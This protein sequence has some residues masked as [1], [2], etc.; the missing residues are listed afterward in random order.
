MIPTDPP[1]FMITFLKKIFILRWLSLLQD[2]LEE[3]KFISI[4][5]GKEMSKDLPWQGQNP[6]QGEIANFVQIRI[7][8]S[9]GLSDATADRLSCVQCTIKKVTFNLFNNY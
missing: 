8:W 3:D 7:N 4:N 5:D 6:N 9:P 1:P 2:E